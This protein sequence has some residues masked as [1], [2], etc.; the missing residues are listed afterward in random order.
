MTKKEICNHLG[1]KVGTINSIQKYYK[2]LSS[3]NCLPLF[4][5][6]LAGTLRFGRI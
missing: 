1:L 4:N 5:P 3:I 2:L 6:C